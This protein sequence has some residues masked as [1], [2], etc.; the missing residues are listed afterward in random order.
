MTKP[1][2]AINDYLVRELQPNEPA[3]TERLTPTT[4]VCKPESAVSKRLKAGV[5]AEEA[6]DIANTLQ[7]KVKA[8]S[9][10]VASRTPPT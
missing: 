9:H 7:A 6:R 4:I 2:S 3:P 10:Q 5:T 1:S 8:L